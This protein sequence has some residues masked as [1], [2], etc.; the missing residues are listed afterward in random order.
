MSSKE[1]FDE[2]AGRWDQMRETFFSNNVRK[3]AVKAVQVRPDSVAADVGAG[4]GFMTE[5]LLRQGLRVIAV[6]QSSEMIAMM[7]KRFGGSDKVDFRLGESASLPI[8]NESVDFVFANMYLHHVERPAVAIEE[9]V[10]IL[11][12]GG[13]LVITDADE[14]TYEFLRTEQHDRWLGFKKSD[15]RAWFIAAGLT[16]V[17]VDSVGEN[18]RSKSTTTEA[19]VAISI[20]IATGKKELLEGPE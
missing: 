11:K 14:H 13:S 5:E 4:T 6:D 18:C 16:E 10:R 9:M 12:P 1:Y 3:A 20:F 7:K 15:I 8:V 17:T 2:V 19:Q